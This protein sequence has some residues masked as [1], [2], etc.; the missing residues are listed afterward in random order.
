[1]PAAPEDAN[2]RIRTAS[3]VVSTLALCT[4]PDPVAA[5]R[6]AV[7]V[8][9]PGGRL[10]CL[11]HGRADNRV[12]N[13]ILRLLEPAAVRREGDHLLREPDLIFAGGGAVVETVRR[14]RAARSG[15]CSLTGRT[16]GGLPRP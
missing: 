11:E 14:N 9:I 12:A 16:D 13:A 15:G 6:E 4:V 3:V 5:V 10:H 8:L 1:M 2:D 7:W